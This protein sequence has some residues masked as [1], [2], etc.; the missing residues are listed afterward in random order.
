MDDTPCRLFFSHPTC[1]SQR[2]YEA[3]RAVFI[4]GLPQKEAAERSGYSHDAFR[5][6]VHEFRQGRA[7]ADPPPFSPPPGADAL[8]RRPSRRPGGPTSP[9]RPTSAPSA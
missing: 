2:R 6:L 9:T 3:L 8:P 1:P 4:D 7:A 5:Q